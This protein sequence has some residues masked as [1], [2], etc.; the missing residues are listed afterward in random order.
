MKEYLSYVQKL[1]PKNEICFY[2]GS[3]TTA[4]HF[5]KSGDRLIF[6]EIVRQVF[7]KL[8]K[9]FQK[10]PVTLYLGDG[11]Q[12]LKDLLPPK[13]KQGI[14]FID[15]PYLD[16][17][18]PYLLSTAIKEGLQKWPKGIFIL[19]YDIKSKDVIRKIDAP[20]SEI[21]E[22]YFSHEIPGQANGCGLLLINAPKSIISEL[23]FLLPWLKQELGASKVVNII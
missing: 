5:S 10:T 14:V 4:Y 13:E 19:W 6:C 16:P 9:N 22:I 21:F 11:L 12:T 8:K 7:Q 17:R 23:K 18:E 15:P 20:N 1:N 2:P 3:P